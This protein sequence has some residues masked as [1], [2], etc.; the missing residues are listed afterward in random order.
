MPRITFH[1]DAAVY[2][3]NPESAN[4][5]TDLDI[6]KNLHGIHSG[7]QT[8]S[9]HASA[10]LTEALGLGGGRMRFAFDED[11]EKFQITTS[12]FVAQK[13]DTEQLHELMQFTETQWQ[14]S[15]G[16][17]QF[18]G[19]GRQ[20]HSLT[21]AKASLQPVE[22]YF[23][24]ALPEHAG[25]ETFVKWADEGEAND[26][27]LFD[28]QQQ[29]Q[30]GNTVAAV[31][32]AEL[33]QKGDGVAQDEQL[34][35]TLLAQ[36]LQQDCPLSQVKLAD[37]LLEGRGI[38]ADPH[39]AVRLLNKSL[40]TQETPEALFRL[41]EIYKRGIGTEAQPEK[42]IS[43]LQKATDLGHGPSMAELADCY[44]QGIGVAADPDQ[45]KQLY[46][47]CVDQG[48]VQVS[49]AL[50]RLATTADSAA[51]IVDNVK[52]KSGGLF[53]LFRRKKK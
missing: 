12:Y 43:F 40:E 33:Y 3:G 28:L 4:E 41:G 29:I 32:M 24:D 42:A 34:A 46:Q 1:S 53:G 26:Y 38:D 7:D 16:S 22:G 39:M 44:E 15:L 13:P 18:T 51:N 37:A 17:N 10:E 47:N 8:C 9:Q 36:G 14:N 5:V 23:V 11:R 30:A 52:K 25:R 19:L 45:A 21:Y 27:C 6:L 2:Q 49:S 35:A 50:E 31:E 20:A 48:N